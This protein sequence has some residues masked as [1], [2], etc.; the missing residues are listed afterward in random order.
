MSLDQ[1]PEST[2]KE[3]KGR[4]ETLQSAWII[5][6]SLERRRQLNEQF[7]A[8]AGQIEQKYGPEG[9]KVV[10]YVVAKQMALKRTQ[11]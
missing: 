1:A 7:K 6:M 5:A 11:G 2:L 10:D 9:K 3:L 8:L 4:L